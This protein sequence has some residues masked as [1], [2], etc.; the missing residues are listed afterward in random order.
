MNK[1]VTLFLLA[2]ILTISGFC[3]INY[4]FIGGINLWNINHNY[5]NVSHPMTPGYHL[6]FNLDFP[7]QDQSF[8]S[9]I[10]FRV[11]SKTDNYVDKTASTDPFAI[12]YQTEIYKNYTSKPHYQIGI[13]LLYN[14]SLF[15]LSNS[16]GPEYNWIQYN[17]SSGNLSQTHHTVGFRL[18][19]GIQILEHVGLKAGFYQ[20]VFS[21]MELTVSIPELG[22]I[23][24][25]KS[26]SQRLYF[27]LCYSIK[28]KKTPEPFKIKYRSKA[29]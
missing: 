2:S 24:T 9:G 15:Q 7:I 8:T 5:D 17:T 16:I 12:I 18:E 6:G 11:A 13:P 1:K 3:Q 29:N 26:S 28:P 14:F 25:L 4:S 27:T 19:T 21:T 10:E 20:S 23:T 22:S